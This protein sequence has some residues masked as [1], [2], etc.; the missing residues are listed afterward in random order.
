M[1]EWF[2]MVEG[3]GCMTEGCLCD[4][5]AGS[6]REEKFAISGKAKEEGRRVEVKRDE[7]K[8]R[9]SRAVIGARSQLKR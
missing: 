4:C 7:W 6:W 1:E 9:E 8:A 5:V 2:L 3:E